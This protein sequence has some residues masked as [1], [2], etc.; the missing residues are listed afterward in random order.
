M[1]MA[2]SLT[3]DSV[4]T[5]CWGRAEL[6]NAIGPGLAEARL[7][8]EAPKASA[9]TTSVDLRKDFLQGPSPE[10]SAN[11]EPDT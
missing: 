3:A 5:E 4:G 8:C 10:C 11:P 9:S 2:I 6:E 1:D 7:F